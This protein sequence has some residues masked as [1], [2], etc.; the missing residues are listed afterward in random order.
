MTLTYFERGKIEG[1]AA[2]AR[3]A[4][5]RMTVSLLETKFRTVLPATAKER[6]EGMPT[7]QLEQLM[8]DTIHAES[9]KELGFEIE[10]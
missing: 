6:L 10:G 7:E 8:R 5:Q 3:K 2:G 4:L 9:L 1:E